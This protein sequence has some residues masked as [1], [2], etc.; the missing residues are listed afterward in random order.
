MEATEKVR[1][2]QNGRSETLANRRFINRKN[3]ETGVF[4]QPPSMPDRMRQHLRK[5]GLRW[6]PDPTEFLTAQ[7]EIFDVVNMATRKYL[8][9]PCGQVVYNRPLQFIHAIMEN[10]NLSKQFYRLLFR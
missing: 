9:C 7:V 5:C 6:N 10:T 8:S 3:A 4:Q 2:S 1:F